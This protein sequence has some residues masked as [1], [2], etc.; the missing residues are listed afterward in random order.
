MRTLKSS[1]VDLLCVASELVT[2]KS[3]PVLMGIVQL[4]VDREAACLVLSLGA[5]VG[6]LFSVYS[7]GVT[8]PTTLAY[9][10]R[11]IQI[12]FSAFMSLSLTLSIARGIHFDRGLILSL[13]PAFC[14]L[15]QPL[16]HHHW[17]AS[18]INFL[19]ACV[20][21]IW[22]L[23]TGVRANGEAYSM[24]SNAGHA[25]DVHRQGSVEEEMA[26]VWQIIIRVLQLF[27][28]AF[29]AS[30]QHAPVH[31]SHHHAR[32][33][34]VYSPSH[35]LMH[36]RSRLLVGLVG[37]LLRVTFWYL[38]CFLQNNTLHVMLENDH[39]LGGWDWPCCIVYMTAL[40]YSACWTA[41]QIREH[42][43]DHPTAFLKV[44]ALILGLA[45]VYRQRDGQAVFLATGCL[46]LVALATTAL[47][48]R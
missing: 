37:A 4:P 31:S 43:G 44:V 18:A 33:A 19:L 41:T 39:S 42:V 30:V 35:Q 45:A 28:L 21:L 14:I 48:L 10:N 26:T 6:T 46:S 38:L 36:A 47:A 15:I 32:G 29:Y 27:V 20:V 24:E 40:L 9:V 25:L 11:C 2:G 5:V 34:A 17:L 1:L 12:G 13:A 16:P 8:G 23:S 22:C 7:I 3:V